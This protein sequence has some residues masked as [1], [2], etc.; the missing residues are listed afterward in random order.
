MKWLSQSLRQWINDT[1][2]RHA[3]YSWLALNA[4]STFPFSI[5]DVTCWTYFYYLNHLT[6][7]IQIYNIPFDFSANALLFVLNQDI[8]VT[9][10]NVN[11]VLQ[12]QCIK[13]WQEYLKNREVNCQRTAGQMK[14]TLPLWI[15]YVSLYMPHESN[16]DSLPENTATCYKADLIQFN[17]WTMRHV[18]NAVTMLFPNS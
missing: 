5:L 9:R 18:I 10:N 6:S 4:L 17:S 11:S 1:I 2:Y 16:C 7:Y 15:W 13:R 3:S 12:F 8:E 14:A